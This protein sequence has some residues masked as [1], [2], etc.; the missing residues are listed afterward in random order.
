M[1]ESAA[2]ALVYG[3]RNNAVTEKTVL[4][5]D[6]GGGSSNASVVTIEDGIIE[7][8]AHA[9]DSHLGGRDFDNRLVDHFIQE[10]KRKY[11]KDISGCKQAIQRLRI[12]CEKAKKNLSKSTQ[13]AI[14]IQSLFEGIDYYTSIHRVNFEEICSDQFRCILDLIEKTLRDA[15][16]HKNAIDDIVLVGGSTHIPKIQILIK[17]FFNGE[18]L[19]LN[20]MDSDQT[21]AY[22]AAIQGSVFKLNPYQRHRKISIGI[23]MQLHA[24]LNFVSGFRR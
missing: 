14:E 7:V 22:G 24:S 2:A 6:I 19:R 21:I 12:D 23:S 3:F 16:I 11:E 5:V 17:E 1:N 15:R 20:S 13:A 4:I 10:F 18:I 8:R 9:G